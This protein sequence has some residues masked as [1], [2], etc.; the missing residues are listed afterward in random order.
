MEVPYGKY[1]ESNITHE[2][3]LPLSTEII[4]YKA[5][6][7]DESTIDHRVIVDQIQHAIVHTNRNRNIQIDFVNCNCD[8]NVVKWFIILT[9]AMSILFVFVSPLFTN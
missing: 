5:I 7:I 8:P 6:K 9:F 1:V 4:P 2:H 3:N